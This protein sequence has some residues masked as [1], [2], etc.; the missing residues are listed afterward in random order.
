MKKVVSLAVAAATLAG[1]AFA[2]V[3]FGAW[4]RGN[5][6]LAAPQVNEKNDGND[7]IT[8][9]CQSWTGAAPRA[10]LSVS[11]NGA[12]VGFAFDIHNN[13]SAEFKQGDNAYIWA[14]PIDQVKI[15]LGKH[16]VNT[17]RGD[18]CF[19]LWN[20]LRYGVTKG[21]KKEGEGFLFD[22]M[23]VDGAIVTITPIENLTLIAAMGMPNTNVTPKKENSWALGTEK[24]GAVLKDVLGE[25]SKYAVAYK[26]PNIATFKLGLIE[27]GPTN[28][29]TDA[30]ETKYKNTINASVE[31]NAI[32]NAFIGIGAFIPTVGKKDGGDSTIINLYGNYKINDDIKVHLKGG[33]EL[34]TN[35]ESED[36]VDDAMG[37]SVSAGVDYKLTDSLS[38]Y[39][40]AEYAN[41]VYMANTSKRSETLGDGKTYEYD[42]DCFDFGVGVKKALSNGEIGISV[43]GATHNYGFYKTYDNGFAWAVPVT[44]TFWF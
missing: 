13:G 44:I 7:I 20:T 21:P 5:W 15:S 31:V 43:I 25:K 14:K 39:A 42:T 8:G 9:Q 36:K 30:E 41:G 6:V 32:D 1:T 18:A 26:I 38:L 33:V 28:E 27:G 4:G 11:G 34:N 35:D 16:D 10:G 12:N 22:D 24:G 23:D 3:N 2:D 17:L 29:K 37:F 19:G 40:Q